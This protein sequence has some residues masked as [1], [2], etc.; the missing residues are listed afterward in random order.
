MSLQYAASRQREQRHCRLVGPWTVVAFFEDD[1]VSPSSARLW[2]SGPSLPSRCH[3]EPRPTR[4]GSAS[5]S[6]KNSVI[7]RC[8]RRGKRGRAAK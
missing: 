4:T 5:V 1:C 8:A 2:G 6:C 7:S 3:S